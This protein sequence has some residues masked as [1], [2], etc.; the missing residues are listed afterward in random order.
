LDYLEKVYPGLLRESID[1]VSPGL[2]IVNLVTY[3][4]SGYLD[5]G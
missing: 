2:L 1:K 5:K 3:R 4:K